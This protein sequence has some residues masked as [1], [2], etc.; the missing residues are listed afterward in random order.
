M[1][2][3]ADNWEGASG[4]IA[5]TILSLK[6]DSTMPIGIAMNNAVGEIVS[7]AMDGNF[8]I[9]G[10]NIDLDDEID[11]ESYKIPTIN[12]EVPTI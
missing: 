2:F 6:A 9:S 1:I 7:V 5:G 8:E 12:T 3:M 4:C 10:C 11:T